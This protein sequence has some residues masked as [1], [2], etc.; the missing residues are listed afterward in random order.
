MLE[1]LKYLP[2]YLKSAKCNYFMTLSHSYLKQLLFH[3]K[4]KEILM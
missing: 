4:I 3:G 1:A 2:T